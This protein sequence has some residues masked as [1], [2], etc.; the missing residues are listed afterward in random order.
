VFSTQRSNNSTDKIF[1]TPA[2]FALIL[3]EHVITSNK[4]PK[5][6]A[7]YRAVT[8]TE[9]AIFTS[10]VTNNGDT[11]QWMP[12]VGRVARHDVSNPISAD[13]WTNSGRSKNRS[14]TIPIMGTT[15]NDTAL[16]IAGSTVQQAISG[17]PLPAGMTQ[18]YFANGTGTSANDAN[19]SSLHIGSQNIPTAWAT[20]TKVFSWTGDARAA[21]LMF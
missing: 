14:L 18:I 5:M 16:F 15:N 2:W 21:G 11:P 10:I 7:F 9:A 3:A 1:T 8:G 4:R 17:Q 13:S 19:P 12:F 20:G 6:V